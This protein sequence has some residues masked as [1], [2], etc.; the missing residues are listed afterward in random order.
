MNALYKHFLKRINWLLA[1]LLTLLGF[2]Q[3]G[4]DKMYP[5]EYGTPHATYA[6]KGKVV[7][8][9]DRPIPRIQ[10]QIQSRDGLRDPFAYAPVDTVYTD[11]Q[12]NFAWEVDFM[13]PVFQVTS[14]DTD[15]EAG[16]GW[17]ASDTLEVDFS[18]EKLTGGE[19]WYEGRAEKEVK[20]IL[21]KYVDPHTAP[22]V[23]YTFYGQ[24]R[25]EQGNPLPGVCITTTPSYDA[26][27]T[28]AEKP[29]AART[30]WAGKYR[31]SYDTATPTEHVFYAFFP[32]KENY[33]FEKDSLILNFADIK[34]YGGQGLLLGKG[35]EELNFILKRQEQ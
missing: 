31:F 9:Q 5:V 21:K 3:M 32:L 6:L 17:F 19:G 12:G 30:N 35:S 34:L 16:G 29:Y 24:V 25:D 18:G 23:L 28:P 26:E 4:C 13:S 14:D 20:I 27:N 33:W 11:A 8:E 2:G 22:Y 10:V 1:G 7:D 15:E